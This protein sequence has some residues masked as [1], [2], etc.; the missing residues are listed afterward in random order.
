MW[1]GRLRAEEDVPLVDNGKHRP[2]DRRRGRSRCGESAGRTPPLLTIGRG[3]AALRELA[4]RT[5]ARVG[6]HR[7]HLGHGSAVVVPRDRC[8]I[9]CT[10]PPG[11]GYIL[12]IGGIRIRWSSSTRFRVQFQHVY[13]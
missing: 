12:P 6:R 13:A 3:A 7:P 4:T 2:H 5:A 11:T 9:T 10:M 8:H 1:R